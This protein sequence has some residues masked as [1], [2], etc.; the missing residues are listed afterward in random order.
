MRHSHQPGDSDDSRRVG[1]GPRYPSTLNSLSVVSFRHCTT[2]NYPK[3]A[4]FGFEFAAVFLF[5]FVDTLKYLH[6]L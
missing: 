5:L 2:R 4:Y 3:A 6:L 1:S